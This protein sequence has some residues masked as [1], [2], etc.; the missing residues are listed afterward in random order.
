[1]VNRD[2]RESLSAVDNTVDNLPTVCLSGACFMEE[3]LIK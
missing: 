1:M 3:R 2:K